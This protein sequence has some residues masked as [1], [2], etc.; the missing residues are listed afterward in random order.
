MSRQIFTAEVKEESV[1]AWS[2]EHSS[3]M[4]EQHYVSMKSASKRKNIYSIP[5]SFYKDT[6]YY[7][8]REE[9]RDAKFN[10]Y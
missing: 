6:G 9:G 3:K 2:N 7:L 1:S 4:R 10:E 5:V 8:Y